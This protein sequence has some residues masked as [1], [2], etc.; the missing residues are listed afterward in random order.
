MGKYNHTVTWEFPVAA[1]NELPACS[2]KDFNEEAMQTIY[3]Q[4]KPQCKV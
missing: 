2:E 1:D 3:I 4:P